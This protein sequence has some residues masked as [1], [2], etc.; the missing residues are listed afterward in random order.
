MAVVGGC[1]PD[2]G[3]LPRLTDEGPGRNRYDDPHGFYG[4]RYVAEELTGALL[5]TMARFRPA[6]NAESRLAAVVG[7]DP[8][9]LDHHDPTQA[10]EDW[11][12]AQRVAR[13]TLDEPRPLVDVHDPTL[14]AALAKHPLVQA[15]I[16]G[17]GLGTRRNPAT[18]DEGVIRL[19]GPVGR[20]ITQ[21]ASRAIHDWFPDYGGIAYRSR[22]DDEEWC[23][24]LWD[25]TPVV[26]ES[27]P[28]DPER[29]HH[30]QGVRYAARRL[31]ILLPDRWA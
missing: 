4:V 20:P 22:L 10:V 2:P 7:V 12:R 27:E 17:S 24:A 1:T 8:D 30:R 9:E 26:I 21:A 23:W 18:L 3:R 14:L 19:G 16:E 15:A 31:E 5:E 25:D 13:V 11:L 6:P 29:R 28:L